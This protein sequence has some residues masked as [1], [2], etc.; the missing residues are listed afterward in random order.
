MKKVWKFLSSMKFAIILLIVLAAACSLGSFI[1]QG[2][3]YEY[4]ASEYGEQVGALIIALSLNDAF[5]SWW[6]IL[7][8]GFLC[9]NL[10]FCNL[11]RLP[12]LIERTKSAAEIPD[13]STVSGETDDPE[14]AM[15]RLGMPSPRKLDDGRLISSKNRAGL[16]GAWVCH[17]G[18]LLLIIGFGLGQSFKQEFTAYG[19]AGQTRALGDTGLNLTIDD[20]QVLL[21]EDD[22]VEQY[23]ADITVC[24]PENGE[25]RSATIS[26]NNPA[27]LF[28]MRFYQNSTGWAARVNVKK[29]GEPLQSEV[30]CAGEYIP[31]A[32]KPELIVSLTAFYPDYTSSGGRPATA[33]GNLNNPAYLYQVYYMGEI[34]GMNI[35]Y[36]DEPLTIDEYEVRFTEPQ[37]YTLIAVKRDPFTPL[38]LLGGLVVTLGLFL[39]FY[40]QPKRVWAVK[41]GE[42]WTLFGECR[43]GGVLFTDAFLRA[44]SQG[45]KNDAAS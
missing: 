9:F 22:T 23:V 45:E 40:L 31:I 27:D 16:W 36:G 12:E 42:S 30:L 39:A 43:K 28:G 14:G 1:Q 5:H 17:L 33:S 19:V 6:F 20:F 15:K 25:C 32:D 18:I 7:I 41:N 44:I 29:D 24:N 34:L 4:Y 8:N 3:S 26:V 13:F 35:L 2:K 21:R 37:S 38:A 10:T 11:I